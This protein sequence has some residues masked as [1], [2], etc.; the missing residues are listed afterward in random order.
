METW[1]GWQQP[2]QGH[3]H[4]GGG[5]YGH[6]GGLHGCDSLHESYGRAPYQVPSAMHERHL[7]QIESGQVPAKRR[8]N[9]LATYSS[10][11]KVLWKYDL[12]H[13]HLDRLRS[14]FVCPQIH[15]QLTSARC[16][17][18]YQDRSELAHETRFTARLT[19]A[20]GGRAPGGRLRKGWRL[21]EVCL[22]VLRLRQR[23]LPMAAK[24]T[25]RVGRGSP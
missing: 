3:A 24:P 21:E 1:E 10:T 12:W 16:E 20:T 6:G 15:D 18:G 13:S 2:T 11:H 19:V 22:S 17:L 8:S 14:Q 23:I 25:R 5:S 9:E 4:N 7:I